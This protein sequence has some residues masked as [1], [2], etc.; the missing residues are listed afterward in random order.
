MDKRRFLKR[1]LI[2]NMLFVIL[3]NHIQIVGDCFNIVKAANIEVEEIKED[4]EDKN[5]EIEIEEM[6]EESYEEYEN[7]SGGIEIEELE[8]EQNEEQEP[9]KETQEFEVEELKE[10]IQ[11]IEKAGIETQA[12]INKKVKSEKGLY[13]QET[14]SI[15]IY[16]NSSNIE[17]A[18]LELD[19]LSINGIE[20]SRVF[21]N[22]EYT[23]S[24]DNHLIIEE[25]LENNKDSEVN[26]KY[27]IDL[28]YE[29]QDWFDKHQIIGNVT[30]ENTSETHSIPIDVEIEDSSE[31]VIINNKFDFKAEN[32]SLYKGFLRA[33]L[34][35]DQQYET[36]YT[37]ISTVEIDN[38]GYIDQIIIEDEVD[39]LAIENEVEDLVGAIKYNQTRISKANYDEIIGVFGFIDVYNGDD[40]VGT[41]DS[42]GE[43]ENDDYV[44]NYSTDYDKLTFIINNPN[45][46]GTLSIKNNKS[47]KGNLD[48]DDNELSNVKA[49]QITSKEK[50]VKSAGTEYIDLCNAYN[51]SEISLEETYSKID[52]ELNKNVF[53]SERINDVS[54]KLTIDNGSEKLELFK[55]PS[56]EIQLPDVVED[57][58]IENVYLIHKNGLSLS[59]WKT[60][61]DETGKNL[62]KVELNGR[63]QEYK[64]G[65]SVNDT[66]IIINTKIKTNEIVPDG[67]SAIEYRYTNEASN[68]IKY[69]VEG[70][71][72]EK[73]IIRHKAKNG[74]LNEFK[75]DNINNQNESIIT[76]NGKNIAAE[77][78]SNTL[79]YNFGVNGKIV[80]N[81]YDKIENVAVIGRTP[82]FGVKNSAGEILNNSINLKL[83]DEISK[84]DLI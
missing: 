78:D 53:S 66:Q 28:E 56:I 57:V 31:S 21:I 60:L 37:T 69:I 81:F 74:L 19:S 2:I 38:V 75:L 71:E 77:L 25:S 27:I 76:V 9:Q 34:I 12:S 72:S 15:K 20:P 11:P 7:D 70:K 3:F 61:K 64:P 47:I 29:N 54:F 17:N 44:L 58:E 83:M 46:S 6:E 59:S 26:L 8:E 45:K 65:Y 22:K 62:I 82:S 49:I 18:Y 32:Q 52:L 35:S 33:N 51:E 1:I 39:K 73:Y 30:L 48:I 67:E 36:N 84:S 80:N 13:V 43:V 10:E 23:R 40:F 50:V 24:N 68:R 16:K 41:I 79:S 5:S 63:Q 42:N 4:N 55:N 14:L